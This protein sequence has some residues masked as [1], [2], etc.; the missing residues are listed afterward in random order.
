MSILK[1]CNTC[2]RDVPEAEFSKFSPAQFEKARRTY[3]YPKCIACRKKEA[4]DARLLLR[5][6]VLLA[7]GHE[8]VC[9]KINEPV[10]LALDH[11][12]DDGA[13]HRKVLKSRSSDAVFRDV[14][15]QGYPKDAYQLLCFN[16][17]EAKRYGV[18]PHQVKEGK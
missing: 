7:Y 1:Q 8:C 5:R 9:C 12:N 3:A 14:K 15:K 13:A 6:K 4:A 2:E 10:F 18:C 17:N 11:V 16:C